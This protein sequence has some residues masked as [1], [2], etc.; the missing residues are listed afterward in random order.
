MGNEPGSQFRQGSFNWGAE[1]K[2]RGPGARA[3]V[4][5]ATPSSD[6]PRFGERVLEAIVSAT[7]CERLGRG[8]ARIKG[9]RVWTT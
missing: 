6:S 1:V 5:V 2:P 4:P 8:A 9:V 3:E 7:T